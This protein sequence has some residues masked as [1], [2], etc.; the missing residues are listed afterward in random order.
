MLIK[1][2][3]VNRFSIANLSARTWLFGVVGGA[4]FVK[5]MQWDDS[6]IVKVEHIFLRPSVTHWLG[7]DSMGRDFLLRILQGAGSS[8]IISTSAIS[9]S[10]IFALFYG[11]IAA[12]FGKKV[13]VI[14]MSLLDVWMSLPSAVLAALV[15]LLLSQWNQS[16]FVVSLMIGST[17]WGRLARLIRGEVL[18]LREKNFIKASESMGASELE[19]FRDHLLPHLKPTL[20]IYTIYQLPNYI[21]T[22]SFLSF[23]GLGV[24]PP[25]TSWGILL[26]E[27]WRSLQVFPHVVFFPSLFLFLTILSLNKIFSS[28][29]FDKRAGEIS[30]K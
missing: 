5:S 28:D 20:L 10:L 14:L 26:Q 8:L 2:G 21:L 25:E 6:N 24:Q 12:W 9:I 3:W 4:I 17:H 30:L 27:G 18:R 13:D 16:L 1:N 11:G 23:I 7:T 29:L 22:E 15:G 19:L